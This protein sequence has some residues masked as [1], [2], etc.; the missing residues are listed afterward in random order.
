M[1]Y[2]LTNQTLDKED[3]EPCTQQ[4]SDGKII[5]HVTDARR[6]VVSITYKGATMKFS[7]GTIKQSPY[8]DHLK[9]SKLLK[10]KQDEFCILSLNIHSLNAKFDELVILLHNLTNCKFSAIC[11]QETWL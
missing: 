11:I 5:L 1:Q 8:V 10:E 9:F 7:G 3:L 4:E 2:S 6:Q